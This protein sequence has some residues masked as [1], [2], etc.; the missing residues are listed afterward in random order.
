MSVQGQAHDIDEAIPAPD[1]GPHPERSTE[2]GRLTDPG[3]GPEAVTGVTEEAVPAA[4]C[5]PGGDTRAVG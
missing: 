2:P 3:Q 4:L 1:P 5:H